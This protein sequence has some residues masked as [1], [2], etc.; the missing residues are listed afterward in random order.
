MRVSSICSYATLRFRVHSQGIL[1][2]GVVPQFVEPDIVKTRFPLL[3]SR[4]CTIFVFLLSM[5]DYYYPTKRVSFDVIYGRSINYTRNI[6][7]RILLRIFIC[8]Y[9][10]ICCYLNFFHKLFLR[11]IIILSF[12]FMWKL[13]NIWITTIIKIYLYN[14]VIL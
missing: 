12:T 10:Y 4:T 14:S 9:I 7:S 1:M 3:A 5:Y 2:Q 13:Y 11:G 8:N 6:S